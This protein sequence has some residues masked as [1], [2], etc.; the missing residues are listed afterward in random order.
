MSI[1]IH[2]PQTGWTFEDLSAIAALNPE[3]RVE[4]QEGSLLVMPPADAEH[5]SIIMRLGVWLSA[6]GYAD[7]VLPDTGIRA[8][9][10]TGRVADLVVLR[11]EPDGDEIWFDPLR[12]LLA[13]EV[14]SPGSE[15]TDRE[16]KPRE[17][18][19]AGI[20]NFWIVERDGLPVVRR[21]LLVRGAYRPT[22]PVALAD[23][24][25]QNPADLLGWDG[26]SATEPAE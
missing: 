7:R 6:N 1:G 18:A 5:N 21:Y 20:A 11:D 10:R 25:K 12:V 16:L 22:P 19:H 14:L 15:S 2:P 4:L 8:G 9:S 23:L 3:L 24:L 13:V 17:Y 26:T